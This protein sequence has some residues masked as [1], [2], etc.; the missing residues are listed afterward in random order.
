MRFDQLQRREFITLLGGAAAAWQLAAQAQ[1]AMPVIGFLHPAQ[2]DDAFAPQLGAFRRGL[3]ELGFV[4]GRNVTI[5]Y[6]WANGQYERLPALAGELVQRGVAVIAAPAGT[7]TVL[8]A[9]AATQKIPIVFSIGSDPVELGLVASLSRPGGNI[10]GVS[11]IGHTLTA[12]RLELLHDLLPNAR[13]MG[14]LVNPTNSYAMSETE[15]TQA[16][17]RSLSLQLVVVNALNV[18]DL[19]RA[20]ATALERRAS[21]LVVGADVTFISWRDRFVALAASNR[22]P[23]SYAFREFSAVGGLMSY[24][25]NRANAYHQVGIYCG[26]ILNGDNPADLPVH[27]RQSS[28]L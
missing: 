27:H 18:G 10:T 28:S 2:L 15:A 22:F 4:E 7:S 13:A 5:E 21:G 26:R 25:S 20:V 1:P 11:I 14:L 9:K 12:K 8:A 3:G 24:G 19:D 23:M 16:V 6:R 17:A